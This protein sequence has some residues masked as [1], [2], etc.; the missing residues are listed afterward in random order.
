MNTQEGHAQEREEKIISAAILYKGELF[1]S[2]NHGDA[3]NEAWTKH[4]NL[5]SEIAK[6]G[7]SII[8]GFVTTTGRFVNR[9]EARKIILG[10]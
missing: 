3:M 9:E 8:E 5:L 2:A 1:V 10:D 7:T 4:P 6:G